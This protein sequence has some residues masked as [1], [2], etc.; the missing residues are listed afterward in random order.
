MV[1]LLV[2]PNFWSHVKV[3]L[4]KTLI[5]ELQGIKKFA[6]AA[7][8]ECQ[9]GVTVSCDTLYTAEDWNAWVSSAKEVLKPMHRKAHLELTVAQAQIDYWDSR[10]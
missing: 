5:A 8:V 1:S 2:P 7:K 3:F 4:D 6:I 9:T 10:L